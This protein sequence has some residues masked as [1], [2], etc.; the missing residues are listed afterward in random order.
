MIV[1]VE[2]IGVGPSLRCPGRGSSSSSTRPKAGSTSF[3]SFGDVRGGLRDWDLARAS[4]WR[5]GMGEKI[6]VVGVEIRPAGRG[7]VVGPLPL[8]LASLIT[9]FGKLSHVEVTRSAFSTAL[10]Y[11]PTAL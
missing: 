11:F 2:E 10:R 4:L 3:D 9:G 5:K 7:V 6:G 1:V 8:V